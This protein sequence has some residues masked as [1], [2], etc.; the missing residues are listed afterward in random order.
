MDRNCDEGLEITSEAFHATRIEE[1]GERK[2]TESL[3]SKEFPLTVILNGQELVTMLCSPKDMD[4]LAVGFLSSEGFLKSKE[5]I[6]RITVDDIRGVVR[7][8]TVEDKEIARDVLFKRV[9]SSGCG[10][11]A[12]FYTAVDTESH[13]VLSK[14]TVSASDVFSL[15]NIFQKSSQGYLATHGVHS[16][17]LCD[18]EAIIISHEDIGRHNAVDKVFGEC[19]LKGIAT[20]DRMLVVSGRISSEIM[21]KVARRDIPII[22]SVAAP[23]NQ[24]VK[25]AEQLG[26]TLIGSVRGKKMLIYSNDWR[27]VQ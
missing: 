1:S 3:V 6:K 18:A 23:T 21:H 20:H 2:A 9:I 8:E 15:V 27:V 11:G 7:V 12:G 24:G 10:R 13:K 14:T 16:A 25:L 4:F 19:I 22:T 5:D 17:A 26:I